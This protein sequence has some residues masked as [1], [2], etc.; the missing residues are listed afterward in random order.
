MS[1]APL[2]EVDREDFPALGTGAA[3][4]GG[5]RVASVSDVRAPESGTPPPTRA[6]YRCVH[7]A[8]LLRA[9]G[10][11]GTEAT[12]GAEVARPSVLF[13]F[14]SFLLFFSPGHFREAGADPS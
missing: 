3:A 14:L 12:D 1:V 10:E 5:R 2:W 7:R 11:A 13:L 8:G 4:T 6:M 9:S